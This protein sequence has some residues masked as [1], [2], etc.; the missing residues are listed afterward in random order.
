MPKCSEQWSHN[1]AAIG[2]H[3]RLWFCPHMAAAVCEPGLILVLDIHMLMN[4][5]TGC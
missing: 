5:D 2:H 3:V 1:C 4:Q